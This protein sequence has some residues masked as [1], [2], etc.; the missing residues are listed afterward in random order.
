MKCFDSGYSG[1]EAVVELLNID[2]TVRQIIY[3]GTLTQL[4]R[5]LHKCGLESFRKAAIAKVTAGLTTMS[6]ILRVL[7]YSAF[8]Q[9]AQ[10]QEGTAFKANLRQTSLHSAS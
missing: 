2:D 4:H 5:Y 3:D 1:R 7:P 6:E 9:R 8:N 10:V